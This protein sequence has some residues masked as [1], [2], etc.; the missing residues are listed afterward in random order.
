M[1]KDPSGSIL[2]STIQ[3]LALCTAIDFHFPVLNSLF[4]TVNLGHPGTPLGSADIPLAHSL[5]N[6]AHTIGSLHCLLLFLHCSALIHFNH[7]NSM[8]ILPV[9]PGTP[10]FVL[11]HPRVILAHPW[12]HLG[13]SIICTFLFFFFCFLFTAGKERFLQPPMKRAAEKISSK[14]VPQLRCSRVRLG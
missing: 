12:F 9:H 11:A 3:S 1:C 13:V 7:W 2:Q 8:A 6:L 5:T 14:S 4:S 10:L